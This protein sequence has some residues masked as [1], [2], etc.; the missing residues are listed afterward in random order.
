MRDDGISAP[1]ADWVV[2][3]RGVAPGV[4]CG[5]V[6]RNDPRSSAGDV[7]GAILVAARAVPDDIE[8]VLG[9]AGTLTLGGALLSHVSLLSREF[10]KPSVVVGGESGVLLLEGRG[11]GGI[12]ALADRPD[13]AILDEHDVVLLDGDRG[14]LRVPAGTSP[15]ARALIR[16]TYAALKDLAAHP[17]SSAGMAV[18]LGSAE[19]AAV[20]VLP[21]L[22]EAALVCGLLPAG[23]PRRR[24]LAT[25]AGTAFRDEA[26]KRSSGLARQVIERSQTGLLGAW[27]RL[28][29]LSD[30]GELER[31]LAGQRQAVARARDLLADID[32]EDGTL[33]RELETLERRVDA[34]R[35]L[36]RD[37]VRAELS[38]ATRLSQD[39]LGRRIGT[40]RRLLSR[41]CG[42]GLTGEDVDRLQARLRRHLDD[43]H[44]RTGE[45]LVCRIDGSTSPR[46]AL[47]GGKAAGLIESAA[48]LPDGC[49]TPR[50][51]VLS[52]VAYARHIA[53]SVEQ[54][55]RRAVATEA[56]LRV[57]SRLCRSAL[58]GAAVPPEIVAEVRT[59]I[60]RLGTRRIAVRSSATVEDGSRASLAGLLDTYLGVPAEVSAVVDATRRA[61]AS[62]WNARA[63]RVFQ[64]LK[65]LPLDARVAVLVQELVAT[66]ASG[67]LSTRDPAGRPGI[68]LIN[69]ARGLG[70]AISQGKVPGD[71]FWVDRDSGRTLASEHGRS[72]EKVVLDA[73]GRGTVTVQLDARE[74]GRPCLDETRLRRLAQ[75]ARSLETAVATPFEVEFGFGE[76]DWLYLF[77]MRRL[78]AAA[79]RPAGT[80]QTRVP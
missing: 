20:R 18:L 64:T 34:R 10:G 1:S 6:R 9:A 17:E 76:D 38:G 66:E 7:A 68:L 46:R 75:L 65:R 77:Q 42:L 25:L 59:E 30:P 27:E 72:H 58:I 8:R 11:N 50:G 62:L 43:E 24:F 32:R 48:W 54:E 44:A 80:M 39:V 16:E 33:G 23:E 57:V 35:Q 29:N 12:L 45:P 36:L 26:A 49:R 31:E 60:A 67:V 28:Q 52:T 63:L 13:L 14:H 73:A 37:V 61:W 74:S 51:F 5:P 40:V 47:V 70:E 3:G 71:L 69:A 41:A 22:L 79:T 21:F 15:T 19:R 78:P 55:L 2:R 4:A 56:D 53:G